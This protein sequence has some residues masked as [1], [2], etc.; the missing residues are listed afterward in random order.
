MPEYVEPN[1]EMNSFFGHPR[2]THHKTRNWSKPGG[3]RHWFA[4]D[5]KLTLA[6]T[7]DLLHCLP[8]G[9]YVISFDWKY[10]SPS[11]AGAFVELHRYPSTRK[12]NRILRDRKN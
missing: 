10:D 11:D 4:V 3:Q 12:G 9:A 5:S 2:I 8:I 6:E 1:S 7:R